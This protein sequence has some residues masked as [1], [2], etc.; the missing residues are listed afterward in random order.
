M[1]RLTEYHFY[2]RVGQPADDQ[3]GGVREPLVAVNATN[4]SAVSLR[5]YFERCGYDESRLA[6]DY[7]FDGGRAPLV[8]FSGRPWDVRSACIAAIDSDGDSRA[9][10]NKYRTLGAPTVLVCHRNGLDCWRMG[11]EGPSESKAVPANEI[12]RFFELHRQ[13][14]SPQSIYNAK[15]LRPATAQLRQ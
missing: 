2:S 1:D 15:T 9:S 4:L 13:D 8:G 14:L 6:P 3:F 10:A 5:P 12:D 7:P 11:A